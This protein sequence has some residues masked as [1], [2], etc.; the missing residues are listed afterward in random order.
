MDAN[1]SFLLKNQDYKEQFLDKRYQR[2]NIYQKEN[3]LLSMFHSQNFEQIERQNRI[4]FLQELENIFA[5][6]NK[7]DPFQVFIMKK[8][9]LDQ[10][11]CDAVTFFESGKIGINTHLLLEDKVF[12]SGKNEEERELCNASY[13][14]LMLLDCMV[15]ESFHINVA[16]DLPMRM[17]SF[18]FPI[19]YQEQCIYEAYIDLFGEEVIESL[20]QY[21]SIPEEYY[22][23]LYAQ[24]YV[25]N[26]LLWLENK[27]G[28]EKNKQAYINNDIIQRKLE[29]EKSF[30]REF[31]YFLSY[32]EIYP[33]YLNIYHQKIK[34]QFPEVYESLNAFA[35]SEKRLIKCS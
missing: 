12:A 23:F 4:Y 8:S 5:R 11:L 31:G 1:V 22:A 26:K 19:E 7:R 28:K 27:Y 10:M 14:N 13:I 16:Y 15:H 17:R 6:K 25:L 18:D 9:K 3:L 29:V 20:C 32:E 2:L 21:S 33:Y 34:E 24:N 30:E 35:N